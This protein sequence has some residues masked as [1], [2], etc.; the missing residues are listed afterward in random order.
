MSNHLF[1]DTE[2]L[3]TREL[4]KKSGRMKLDARQRFQIN[5]WNQAMHGEIS[6]RLPSV[7]RIQPKEFFLFQF[8]CFEVAHTVGVVQ[9]AFARR[10]GREFW[11]ACGF[12]WLA[13]VLT[14][15]RLNRKFESCYCIDENGLL[16]FKAM[17]DN[18]NCLKGKFLR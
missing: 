2:V 11:S 13:L 12:S 7:R 10:N 6:T 14:D 15:L 1:Q 17:T 16:L 9:Q 3:I 4:T 8:V 18:F 5:V